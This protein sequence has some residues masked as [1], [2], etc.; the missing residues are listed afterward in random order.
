MFRSVSLSP[1]PLFRYLIIKKMHIVHVWN[2]PL[3]IELGVFY[4]S[5]NGFLFLYSDIRLWYNPAC[6]R[7]SVVTIFLNWQMKQRTKQTVFKILK[8]NKICFDLDLVRKAA[9]NTR[10]TGNAWKQFTT[11]LKAHTWTYT[12]WLIQLS[13]T[14]FKFSNTRFNK[15]HLTFTKTY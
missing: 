1:K 12:K 9:G 4:T 13:K 10:M 8:S 14:K 6:Y 3:C 7:C 2:K 15:K 11:F 5:S